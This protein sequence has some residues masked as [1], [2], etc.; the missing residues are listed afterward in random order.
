MPVTTSPLQPP[1]V[2]R[3]RQRADRDVPVVR[4]VQYLGSKLRALELIVGSIGKLCSPGARVLDAFTGS[5]VVAQAIA[6]S[7]RRVLATDALGFP[8]VFAR[9]L[10][11]VG[12]R[13][14]SRGVDQL[15]QLLPSKL[16]ES[17]RV[18]RGFAR[19]LDH[20]REACRKGDAVALLSTTRA[21]PQ[22]HAP[23]EATSGLREVFSELAALQGAS[24]LEVGGLVAAHYAGT[25]FGL[26]Q[27]LV[28]DELRVAIG[29]LLRDET[30]GSWEGDVL[31]TAL[32]SAASDCAFTPGKHFAQPHRVSSEKD[33][34]FLRG[35][36]LQDRR[37]DVHRRF[38]QRA[39]LIHAAGAAA[40]Q[41]NEALCLRTEDYDSHVRELGEVDVV[42]ADPPYTAQQY[43]RFYHVPEVIARYEVP[44]LQEVAGRPT[45]GLYPSGRYLSPFCSKRRAPA[46]F[47]ALAGFARSR[48]APLVVSYSA[49]APGRVGN[50]RMIELDQ[51]VA[52]LRKAG[53]VEVTELGHEYR[54]FNSDDAAVPER[55]NPE[56][57]V[58]CKVRR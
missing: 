16:D 25:Y 3:P 7:G 36:V 17:S 9:A 37:I 53:K 40:G 56:L 23:G 41:G 24:A 30:L 12:R 1:L 34:T 43:S 29:R 14:T 57:L 28:I 35:R 22:L 55:R 5:T 6:Q 19:M 18:V 49:S 31:L 45:A 13:G 32:L 33:L 26:E 38:G 48:R 11:G 21:L 39:R 52:I 42:Y 47:E 54:Q 15:L 50:A 44:E 58:V 10:L 27:A 46:A 51:L 4:P 20:E 2:D 8:V